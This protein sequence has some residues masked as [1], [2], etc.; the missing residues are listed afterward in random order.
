MKTRKHAIL[1]ILLLL[2]T[3]CSN[4]S[5]ATTSTESS[6]SMGNNLNKVQV[7]VLAGQSNMEGQSWIRF[8]SK[9]FAEDVVQQY[10]NGF[11]GVLINYDSNR[12]SNHSGGEF[13]KT[14][15]GQG[16][17]SEQF[18][19]E[20]GLAEQL[21]G[22]TLDDGPIYLVKYAVG[23]TSLYNNWASPSS[24]R[25]GDCYAGLVSHVNAS[26]AKLEN[27][28]LYPEI[29]A[30]C[31][32]QG[33]DDS[34][35]SQA[36]NYGANLRHFIS[37]LR[38][39]FGYYASSKGIG[40]IDAGISNS[41]AWAQYQTINAQKQEVANEDENNVYVDTI[42]NK[43]EFMNEPTIGGDIYHFDSASEIKLGHL[44]A[45]ALLDSDFVR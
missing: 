16:T 36:E 45:S 15:V 6:E 30:I 12:H 44:F 3:A 33:E 7:V 19:P 1:G 42:A 4:N 43:L 32:M 2:V 28:D 22:L 38:S 37:D 21:S 11:D 5:P 24:G 25:T 39:E 27:L 35:S 26:I 41:S 9:H 13:V 10:I 34:N 8:L 23:A 31:F 18:G 17:T 40:F 29:K 20:V 14:K